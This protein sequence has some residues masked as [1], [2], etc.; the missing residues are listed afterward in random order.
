MGA[1]RQ[2]KNYEILTL[3]QRLGRKEAKDEKD[4]NHLIKMLTPPKKIYE[5]KNKLYYDS[6]LF[7]S[8][9]GNQC[10]GFSTTH[11]VMDGPVTNKLDNPFGFAMD[12]YS[13]AQKNDE[14]PGE[15][16]EGTSV[17]GA[18]KVLLDQGRIS[19][20][21]WGK[22]L[23]SLIDALMMP[24]EQGGGPAV[25]GSNWYY[26]MFQADKTGVISI[27]NSTE[28]D[29]AGGHAYVI[30]AI[31]IS[32]GAY[33]KKRYFRIKNSWDKTW[34]LNGRAWISFEDVERLIH[35]DGEVMIALENKIKLAA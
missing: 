33:L 26:S 21:L 10:V 5:P 4:N 28:N 30:N 16:Y 15:D 18:A 19:R 12:L 9:P 23:Q 22:D 20:Y 13:E 34:A 14:W 8:Q 31:S 29:I 24:K 3:A 7:L 32:R 27:G 11:Y 1:V 17:R 6:G 35:E 25:I 2:L